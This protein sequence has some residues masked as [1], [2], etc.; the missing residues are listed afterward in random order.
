MAPLEQN[1][2]YYVMP[3]YVQFAHNLSSGFQ[4]M[5]LTHTPDQ[6]LPD[7][8]KLAMMRWA[9]QLLLRE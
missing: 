2:D 9:P 5:V 6:P 8:V 3:G 7:D 1:R 4:I